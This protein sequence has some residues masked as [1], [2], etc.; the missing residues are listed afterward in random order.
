[1]NDYL[2]FCCPTCKTVYEIE[3]HHVRPPAEPVCETCQRALPVAD[4][5]D[6]L[7]YRIIRSQFV[8]VN[9][10]PR[11]QA[12]HQRR[13]AA[14]CG[15]YRKAAASHRAKRTQLS[16]EI[17]WPYNRPFPFHSLVLCRTQ[18]SLPFGARVVVVNTDGVCYLKVAV[19]FA[20]E[21]PCVLGTSKLF[22]FGVADWANEEHRR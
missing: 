8:H 6:W 4:G 14:D 1:M 18:R 16:E 2:I 9:R 7:T 5:N 11:S 22:R 3:P 17:P 15:E 13:G 21:T 12:A 19:D 20:I 10:K